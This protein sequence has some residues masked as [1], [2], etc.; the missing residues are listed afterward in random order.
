MDSHGVSRVPRYLGDHPESLKIFDYAAV[1]L[2]GQAF[3]PVLLILG[4]LTP[5]RVSTLC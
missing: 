2:F 3:H 4:F 1:T 5:C